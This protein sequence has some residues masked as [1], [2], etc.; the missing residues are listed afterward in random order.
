MSLVLDNSVSMRW[1]FGDG[2][3]SDLDYAAAV[4]RELR[5][6]SATV[7]AIWGLE[8]AN[9]LARAEIQGAITTG[10]RDSFLRLL[11]AMPIDTDTA[12]AR[13]ALTDTLHLAR[14]HRL[15]AYDASYLELALRER[16]PLATLD[17]ALRKAAKRVGVELF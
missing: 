8:V 15:S 1:C 10:R 12:T 13:H 9:V 14:L 4:A 6:N 11:S 3:R 17:S 16:L 7:P 5:A 2:K